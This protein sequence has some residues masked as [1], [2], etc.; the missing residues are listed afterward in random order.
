MRGSLVTTE[1]GMLG[2]RGVGSAGRP[3]LVPAGKARVSPTA[4]HPLSTPDRVR[5]D[6]DFARLVRAGATG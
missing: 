6:F 5:D 2:L 1:S 4:P 3:V